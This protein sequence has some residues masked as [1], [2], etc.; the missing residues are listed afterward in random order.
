MLDKYAEEWIDSIENIDILN[1]RPFRALWS[2]LEIIK[3]FGNKEKYLEAV[4]EV[5][6]RI[7]EVV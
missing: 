3:R 2:P 7:Y 4:R 6:E 5:E 1:V